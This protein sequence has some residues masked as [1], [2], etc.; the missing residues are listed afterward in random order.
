MCFYRSSRPTPAASVRRP[1]AEAPKL[2]KPP[3]V[4]A[5]IVAPPAED[6]EEDEEDEELEE[7][8]SL[9]SAASLLR[10]FADEDPMPICLHRNPAG[11][12]K[13]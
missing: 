10:G 13:A 7:D 9:Q 1:A 4:V 2:E 6:D 12:Y 8:D 5:P 11:W 3:V